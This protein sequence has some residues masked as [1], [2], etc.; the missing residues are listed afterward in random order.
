[1]SVQQYIADQEPKVAELMLQLRL[2]ILAQSPHIEES[3]TYNVPFYKYLG[4]LCYLCHTK[5]G[6]VYIGLCEGKHLA[7]EYGLLQAEG[8]TQ[9][10]R[11]YIESIADMQQKEDDLRPTLQEA[12]LVNEEKQ[13][14]KRLKSRVLSRK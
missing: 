8:R 2:L 12:M 14:V 5:K 4:W 10:F 1:M 7:N 6:R 13:K 3:F 11:L 9:V